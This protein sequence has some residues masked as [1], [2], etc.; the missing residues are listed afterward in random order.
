MNFLETIT[1]YKIRF[2]QKGSITKQPV[3]NKK[4]PLP[5]L[6]TT[7]LFLFISQCSLAKYF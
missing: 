3:R 2:S 1:N 4:K 5:F 7:S 6:Y